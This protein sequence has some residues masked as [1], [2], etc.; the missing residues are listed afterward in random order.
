MEIK[1]WLIFGF[2]SLA[3]IASS[4]STVFTVSEKAIAIL[5]CCLGL[6]FYAKE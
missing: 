1:Q 4:L 5:I 2:W 6:T 3:T